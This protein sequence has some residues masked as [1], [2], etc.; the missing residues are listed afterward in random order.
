MEVIG[1]G[2]VFEIAAYAED[3]ISELAWFESV[4]FFYRKL[5]AHLGGVC[6]LIA[7]ARCYNILSYL[8]ILRLTS[9]RG[10]QL[11]TTL[12]IRTGRTDD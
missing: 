5:H 9:V 10:N 6:C 11:S 8:G 4:F 7:L 12:T 3:K 2:W 1:C